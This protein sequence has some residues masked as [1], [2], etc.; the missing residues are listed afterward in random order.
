[1]IM[2]ISIS[3]GALLTG[4]LIH[5]DPTAGYKHKYITFQRNNKLVACIY[6]E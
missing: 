2:I 6:K 4:N 1:M 5:Y 3:I